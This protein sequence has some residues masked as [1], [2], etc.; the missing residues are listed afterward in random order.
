MP[1][2]IVRYAPVLAA[3]TCLED[4]DTA[5]GAVASDRLGGRITAAQAV[6]LEAEVRHLREEFLMRRGG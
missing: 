2:A 1:A 6:T 5:I 3:P 4:F